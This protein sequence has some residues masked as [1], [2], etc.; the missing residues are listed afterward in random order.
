MTNQEAISRIVPNSLGCQKHNLGC[1]DQ[2]AHQ[3]QMRLVVADNDSGLIKIESYRFFSLDDHT[4]Y[5][6]DEFSAGNAVMNHHKSGCMIDQFMEPNLFLFG[7]PSDFD[8]DPG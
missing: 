4:A 1:K 7:H 6:S 8:V 5:F 3:I 2:L